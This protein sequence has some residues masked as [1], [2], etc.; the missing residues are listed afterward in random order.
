ME[1]VSKVS[2]LMTLNKI[3]IMITN[4]REMQAY[5][6]SNDNDHHDYHGNQCQNRCPKREVMN[7][8]C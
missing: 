4:I 5:N 1:A 2:M 7:P 6:D 8:A 3:I